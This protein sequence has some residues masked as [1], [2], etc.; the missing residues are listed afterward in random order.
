MRT[1]NVLSIRTKII[2]ITT[3]ILSVSLGIH[4]I[5]ISRVF[6]KEYSKALL[7][8]ASGVAQT[9][10]LQL[11]R[12]MK[13]GIALEEIMGFEKQC[14][15]IVNEH[16]FIVYAMIVDPAGNILFHNHPSRKGQQTHI[17]DVRDTADKERVTEIFTE[18]EEEFYE[19]ILP[20]FGA[21][22]H[23]MAWVKVGFPATVIAQKN[24][25]IWLQFLGV[26]IFSLV[27]AVALLVFALSKS[28]TTPLATLLHVI[29]D[30][31]RRGTYSTQL[32]NIASHDEFGQLAA[33]FDD[34]MLEIRT[35]HQQIHSY[36]QTLEARVQ[37][38]TTELK[39]VNEQLSREI[40]E[41]KLAEQQIKLSLQEKEVLLKEIHHRVKNNM[42]VISSLLNLQANVL[43]DDRER[44][45]LRES[46]TRIR[47]MA[48][49]HEKLYQSDN[50]VS[51]NFQ[52]YTR[53]LAHYLQHSYAVLGNNITFVIEMRDVH[54]DIDTAIPC[55]LILNELMSNA[56]KYAF[57]EGK[58]T[59]TITLA[60]TGEGIHELEF[61]DDGIGLPKNFSLDNVDS[62][63]LH[64]V[65]GL[66]EEQLN[67]RL[68]M[69]CEHGTTWR[70]QFKLPQ[71]RKRV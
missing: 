41:R 63:G 65:K 10:S 43:Q 33:A 7:L 60:V 32:T 25:E 22:D 3:L 68:E 69:Q 36:T 47:A 4:N 52:D 18:G 55:G 38:R 62:L 48:L 35:S 42:Q 15:N 16:D 49:I 21:H 9:L 30:V 57:P 26:T 20:I 31:Q 67:G 61:R 5:I 39:A 29:R 14:Q 66:A 50:L 1:F 37:K 51:I 44:A 19:S 2:C 13:L 6:V 45:L 23:L 53:T 54:F 12:I 8:E 64:L 71:E 34:M 28:V 17:P 24:R 40:D 11:D 70:L 58:G 46:Q 56:L 27:F 59:V